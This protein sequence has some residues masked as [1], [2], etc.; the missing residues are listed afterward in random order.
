V[1][2]VSSL[3]LASARFNTLVPCPGT[4]AFDLLNR[5][6]KV[7]IRRDWADFAV[8]YMWEVDDILYVP[9]GYNRYE[10]ILIQRLLHSY[11]S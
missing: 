5:E 2:L 8:Q 4:P 10:L 9:D 11:L 7:L 1:K 6:G 3:P